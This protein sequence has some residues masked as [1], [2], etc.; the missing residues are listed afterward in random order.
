MKKLV[1][2]LIL[3]VITVFTFSSCDFSDDSE[4]YRFEFVKIDSVS[5]P[6]TFVVGQTYPIKVYY[7]LPTTCHNFEGFYYERNQNTRTVAVQTSVYERNDC[8]PTSENQQNK[9]SSFDFYV[10]NSESY[11]FKFF[12]GEDANGA[13][14]FLEYEVP[15]TE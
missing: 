9:E 2:F 15:V 8:E 4:K 5:I 13:N 10:S 11:I 7:K 12:Q 6:E 14:V 1:S 3:T